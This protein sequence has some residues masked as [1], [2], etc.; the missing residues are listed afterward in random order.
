[1]LLGELAMLPRQV[2][3]AGF[4]TAAE[5]AEAQVNQRPDVS[6]REPATTLATRRPEMSGRT[7]A[8]LLL[9]AG[10][11][12]VVIAVTIFTVADWARIGP[13]GRSAF[14]AGAT[15]LVLAAP[16]PLIRRN[17]NATGEAIAAIGLALTIGD[18]YLLQRL[19]TAPTGPLGAAAFCAA[20]AAAWTAYGIRTGLKGPRVAA[21]CLAQLPAPLALAGI[22]LLL[23]GPAAP[24]AG[25]VAVGLVLTSGADVLIA[26][27]SHRRARHAESAVPPV[28]S[29]AS[30]APV[31]SVA[32]VAAVG[33]WTCGVLVTAAASA[34]SAASAIAAG[35]PGAPWLAVAFAAAA[36]VGTVAPGYSANLRMLARPAAVASGALAV[37]SLVIP[38]TAAAPASWDLA[39]FAACG[40][41]VCVGALA[42]GRRVGR[43][44]G[45]R[46]ALAAAGSAAT[47]AAAGLLAAPVALV[48][49]FGWHRLMPVWA[50]YGPR[51]GIA[52][53]FSGWPGLPSTAAALVLAGLAC[54]L[55]RLVPASSAMAKFTVV[56]RI[57]GLVAAALAAGSVPAAVHL[58]GWAAQLTLT[59]AAV[60]FLSVST[61]LRDKVLAGVAA[62]SGAALAAG[63]ALWSLAE[64]RAT[65]AELAVL[66]GV[67]FLAAVRARHVFTAALSAAGVLAATTGVAWAVPLASGWHPRYAAFAALGVAIAAIAAATAL[68][69]VRPVHSVVLDLG[70]G[71]VILLSAIV[72]AGQRDTF[73]MLVAAVAVVASGTAWQR[74]GWRRVAA[75]VAAASAATATLATEWRPIIHALAAPGYVITHPWQGYAQTHL[76]AR[77][78]GL[79]LAV[80]LLAI[81]LAALAAAVGAWRRSGR[82]GLDAVAVALPL[83]AAPAGTDGLAAGIGYW[84]VGAA[85]L[86]LA[87]ALTAWAAL[88]RSA[89]PA[90]AALL[91]GAM[92]LAWALAKPL[93]TLAALGCLAGAYAWCAWRARLASIRVA[94]GCLTVLAATALAWCAALAAGRP[95]WQAGMAALG[96]AAFAQ[97]A[98][99]GCAHDRGA[100]RLGASGSARRTLIEPAPDPL[101]M[102]APAR[103][104]R[105]M[106]GL[107][108]EITAWL[109]T[110]AGVGPCLVRPST[111]SL[112]VATAGIICL[113]VSARAARRPAIWPGL[114]LCYLAWCL[115]LAVAGVAVV[116]PYTVPAAA[117]AIIVGWLASRREPR[118]HSWLA[119]GP[120]LSLLL[121]PSLIVGWES[122][123]WIRP[124]LVGLAAAAIAIAGARA[125]MQAPLLTGAIVAVLDAGR[126]LAPAFARLVHVLPGWIPVAALGAALL[127]AGAT[128]EAR[129]RNLNAIRRTLA[130]MS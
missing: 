129:L 118:P 96:V 103:D 38:V 122:L 70:A 72:A 80:V 100:V 59:G 128:Y 92:A 116:E 41:S 77:S 105:A 125:R 28:A 108:I 97:L 11:A 17:L 81:C 75:V 44:A 90:G 130:A 1:M 42:M 83:V 52:A 106:L 26:E 21:I 119:Y 111:A 46:L 2:P 65:I 24:I 6:A 88:G 126:E 49:L 43:P 50:G 3:A 64:P 89:A 101:G 66:A 87:L 15:A 57:A 114:A 51:T 16:R 47:L 110:V 31:A 39:L 32:A 76:A 69:R 14:L 35:W 107:G 19:I 58:T 86:T 34:I 18:A 109:V 113:G 79:S 12:L 29:V 102:G 94:A 74:A 121:L 95:S 53:G 9:G 124:V 120:G 37:M 54:L 71:P 36:V 8:R 123:G 56:A 104:Q 4:A 40:F 117:L 10:A 13:L 127:W 85:L 23:G 48:G 61:L 63:A 30:V 73:A 33:A 68:Q 115:A 82:A 112:A 98:A 62:G 55:T 93:P 78:P 67:F 7:A 45:H 27:L 20:L 84:V 60:A 25:P 91:A 22:A 5:E 99:A